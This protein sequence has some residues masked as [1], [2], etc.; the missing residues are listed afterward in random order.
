[1]NPGQI[2]LTGCANP[3][4]GTISTSFVVHLPDPMGRPNR[5]MMVA[6]HA[7]VPGVGGT[8]TPGQTYAAGAIQIRSNK[9]VGTDVCSGCTEPVCLTLVSLQVFSYDN[10][11]SPILTGSSSVTWQGG[12]IDDPTSACSPVGTRR[13]TWGA[14]KSLYR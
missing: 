8:L 7:I 1:V 10:G 9:A 4:E 6:D 3:F 2:G 11:P 5:R 14:V 12:K 13:E